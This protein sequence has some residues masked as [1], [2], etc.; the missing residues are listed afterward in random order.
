MKRSKFD[1]RSQEQRE[2]VAPLLE[3][4]PWPREPLPLQG[5]ARRVEAWE[6]LELVDTAAG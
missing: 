3:I 2:R 6:I 1:V 4:S 5:T